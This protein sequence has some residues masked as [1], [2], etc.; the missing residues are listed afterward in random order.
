MTKELKDKAKLT[1]E[2]VAGPLDG[3]VLSIEG[4]TFWT[5]SR[6]SPLGFPWDQELGNPQGRFF[7]KDGS[8]MLESCKV[9]HGTYH[10]VRNGGKIEQAICLSEGD[11]LKA[12]ETWL[13]VRK[14]SQA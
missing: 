12:S 4:E 2:I 11:L 13:L 6:S 7:M 10:C 8:W 9:K 5:C 1:L 14:I 3:Y